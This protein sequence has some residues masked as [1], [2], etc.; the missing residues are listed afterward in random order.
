MKHIYF[1]WWLILLPAAL[2]GCWDPI[3]EENGD[4]SG[5]SD[6]STQTT[7]S[8]SD[9][10]ES[11]TITDSNRFD[12]DTVTDTVTRTDGPDTDSG[13][14][15]SESSSDT[16]SGSTD[17]GDSETGS[18][19]DINTDSGT[20]LDTD[21]ETEVFTDT[22]TESGTDTDTES[23]TDTDTDTDTESGTD[24]DTESGT[25]TDTDTEFGTDTD[26]D[27]DTT[28]ATIHYFGRFDFR[29]PESPGCAWSNCGAGVRFEGGSLDVRLSGA[30]SISFQVVL[31]GQLHMEIVTLGAAMS[32]DPTV[33]TYRIVNGV[34]IGIHDVRM[35]RNPE[36]MFGVVKFH[37]FDSPDGTLLASPPPFTR[38]IEIIG[39]AIS[40]GYG[41]DGCPFSAATEKGASAYGPLV[42]KQLD[43]IV[44]VEAWSGKG[45][46]MNNDG[47]TE[48][49]IPDLYAYSL[50]G[51]TQSEWDYSQYIP[52]AVVINLGTHDFAANVNRDNYISDYTAFVT[53]LRGYYPDALIL[54]AINS[55]TNVFSDE[56]DEIIDTLNDSNVKKIDLNS[57]NWKGCDGY[58]DLTAHQAMA[59]TLTTRLQEELGW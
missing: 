30:G 2:L 12:S 58:P 15:D 14:S 4:D 18:G 26:T 34:T 51:D 56:I 42:A 47:S 48:N 23:G 11:D 10:S 38:R 49:V 40:A 7:D 9:T 24:T 5:T 16:E 20:D 32:D 39:D 52:D 28:T 41:N 33:R 50:P 46:T 27:T 21:S 25:D 45:M 6:T 57:P 37:G 1:K 29:E 55:S 19:T 13:T 43:A 31:D 54:C 8:N 3:P 22:D 17:T 44:H 59:N 35:Y 53:R 36:A